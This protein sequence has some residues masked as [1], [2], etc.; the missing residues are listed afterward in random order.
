MSIDAI[1]AIGHKDNPV[2]NLTA[3]QLKAI[4]DGAITNWSELVG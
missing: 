3:A 4:Y 1:V 2:Q